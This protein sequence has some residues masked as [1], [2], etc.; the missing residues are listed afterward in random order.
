[1]AET[2]RK[3]LL[4]YL[5]L[6]IAFCALGYTIYQGYLNRDYLRRSNRPHMTASFFFNEEG[7]GFYFGNSGVGQ[8]HLVWF[9]ILVDGNPQQNWP[10]M[11]RSLGFP[12]QPAFAGV[13]PGARWKPDSWKKIFWFDPGSADQMLRERH[14]RVELR[15]CYC[16]IFE[17]F[18]LGGYRGEPSPIESCTP[19]PEIRYGGERSR[20]SANG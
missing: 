14:S 6:L 5:A 3:P 4:D 18:W 2:V 16:S 15:A 9:Q 1:M 12:V 19:K 8:A 13:R 17:E 10:T 20:P 7:S 11:L